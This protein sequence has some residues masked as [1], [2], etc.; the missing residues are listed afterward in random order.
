MV[1]YLIEIDLLFKYAFVHLINQ[2]QQVF[3]R[4]FFKNYYFIHGYSLLLLRVWHF[5]TLK[6]MLCLNGCRRKG[7][8]FRKRSF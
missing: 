3:E 4:L 2:Y 6:S 5:L 8:R 7:Y 1:N